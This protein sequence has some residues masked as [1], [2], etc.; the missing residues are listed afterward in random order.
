MNFR[1]FIQVDF[2]QKSKKEKN[3]ESLDSII[4]LAI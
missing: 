3:E 2:M 4:K 1:Q